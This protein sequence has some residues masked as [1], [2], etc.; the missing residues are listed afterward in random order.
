MH[1][2]KWGQKKECPMLFNFLII[3]PLLFYIF[4]ILYDSLN[5]NFIF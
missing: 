1:V 4:L 5:F 2:N 3:I